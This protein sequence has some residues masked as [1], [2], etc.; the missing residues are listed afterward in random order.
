MR[1][2]T[3]VKIN[4]SDF[5]PFGTFYSMTEP[6]GYPLQGEIHSFYPDR[7]SGTCMGSI[8]FSPIS[9]KKDDRVVRWRSIIQQPGK[10][11]WHWMMI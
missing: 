9:V 10:E 6:E 8:G 4:V 1:E 11:L 5:A 2:L 3:A 7:I